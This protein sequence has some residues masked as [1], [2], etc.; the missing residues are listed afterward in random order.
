MTA[1]GNARWSQETERVLRGAGW[2]PGRAVGVESYEELL[3]RSG[4]FAMHPA[5]RD[6]LAEF[7]G[8][9][10][11]ARGPGISA[12]KADFQ[13]DPTLA[14]GE[15]EIFDVLSEEAGTNLYPLGMMGRR[16]LYIGMAADGR[17]FLGMDS[18]SEYAENG[19]RALEKLVEGIR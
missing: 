16:N 6:F 3:S 5:A 9:E 14:E 18:V 17:V 10:V 15:D 11:E 2:S 12:L 13:I 1:P 8:L 4:G 7:G 19:D